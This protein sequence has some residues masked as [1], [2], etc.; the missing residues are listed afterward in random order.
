MK[1]PLSD[2][3]FSSDEAEEN[4]FVSLS[5][6][7]TGVLF[8]FVILTTA[9]ALHYHL[10]A[11]ELSELTKRAADAQDEANH[12]KTEAEKSRVEA[13]KSKS[14]SARVREALDALAKVLREREQMRKA[15]LSLLVQHL[16]DSKLRLTVELDDTNGILRLPERL[17]FRN[18]EA[19]LQDEAAAALKLL[20]RML[21]PVV[22]KGCGDSALKWEAVYIEGH[23]DNVPIHTEAFASNWELS[24]AR[25]IS[26]F[27]ALVEHQPILGNLLNHQGKAVLGIS[28]YGAQRPVAENDSE[29][30]RQKN[31]RI[32]IRFVMAYPSKAEIEAME[33]QI[34]A[35][36]K[37]DDAP[38]R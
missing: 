22:Q 7:M 24:T 27:N 1:Q 5:D 36:A 13:D 15:E 29:G 18:G 21:R 23:T 25:A 20:A 9:L 34:E 31:R 3:D 19:E 35:A 30:G 8:I 16:R 14:E 6:L 10:K 4:Y 2:H 26:T 38:K 28:G 32:D 17:L 12:S 37:T 11:G 33:K